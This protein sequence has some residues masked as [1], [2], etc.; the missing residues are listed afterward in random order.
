MAKKKD[1][2]IPLG[3]PL[4]KVKDLPKSIMT[5]M[6]FIMFRPYLTEHNGN[7]YITMDFLYFYKN[8]EVTSSFNDGQYFDEMPPDNVL[9]FKAEAFDKGVNKM[10]VRN[11]Y[12]FKSSLKTDRLL[13]RMVATEETI[14]AYN[15]AN[16]TNPIG[17]GSFIDNETGLPMFFTTD[18]EI[19]IPPVPPT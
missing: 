1:S 13:F 7:E 15:Q 6:P 17:G 12:Y 5:H 18:C 4:K 3:I 9:A 19:V 8:L 2:I 11:T 10:V 14:N 16:P